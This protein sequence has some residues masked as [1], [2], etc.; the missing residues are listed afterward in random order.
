MGTQAECGR[1][2]PRYTQT[3]PARASELLS[4]AK[5]EAHAIRSDAT[6]LEAFTRP[7]GLSW[8]SQAGKVEMIKEHVNALGQLL[9]RL[10]EAAGSAEPWQRGAIERITPLLKE[11]ADN[12]EA[13]IRHLN[14]NR[15]NIYSTQLREYAEANYE[16]ASGLSGLIDSFVKY[17]EAKDTFERLTKQLKAGGL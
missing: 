7:K 15:S 6:D 8:V 11:L 12:T 14:E 13:T 16:L 4:D 10:G 2:I 5:E 3:G 1:K 9:G 17:G